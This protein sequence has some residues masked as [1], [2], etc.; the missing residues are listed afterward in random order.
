MRQDR[1]ERVAEAMQ[2]ELS[3]MIQRELKDPRIGFVSVTRV[4]VSRDLGK[5]RVYVSV[6]DETQQEGSL[7]GLRSASGLLRGEIARRLQLRLA[8]VL[9]FHLDHSIEQSVRVQRLLREAGV[10]DGS[11]PGD[12][13]D[14][15]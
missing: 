11:G 3:A 2:A 6:L 5:A 13:H 10:S 12:G 8:P 1:A 7:E 4:D 9:E 15:D 14:G